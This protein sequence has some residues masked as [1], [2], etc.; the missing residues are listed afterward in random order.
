[1]KK[2]IYI[3]AAALTVFAVS[4]SKDP[5]SGEQGG[6]DKT[7]PV[8]KTIS[9]TLPAVKA[10]LSGETVTWESSDAISVFDG[11][12]NNK[13]TMVSGTMSGAKADFTGKVAGDAKELVAVYPYASSAS[14]TNG[15]VAGSIAS[16]QVPVAAGFD[17]SCFAAVGQV[18]GDAVT[19]KPMVGFVKVT[20]GSS[21]STKT[22]SLMGNKDEAV[23]GDY[24]ATVDGTTVTPE[25]SAAT[26]ILC[27]GNFEGGKSYL[28][29]TFGGLKLNSGLTVSVDLGGGYIATKKITSGVT[30]NAGG[31][32]AVDMAN[33]EVTQISVSY[34]TQSDTL[35]FN[36]GE[37]KEVEVEG[38]NIATIDFDPFGPTGWTTDASKAS[39]GKV[40]ITAPTTLE[41]VDAAANMVLIG[42]AST[43]STTTDT[44]LVRLAGINSKEDLVACRDAIANKVEGGTAPYMV[45]GWIT[46]N[47]DVAIT[48]DD[49]LDKTSGRYFFPVI[50]IPIN[51]QNKTVTIN[52]SYDA[53]ALTGTA[54]YS[55]IQWLKADMKDLTLAGSMEIKNAPKKDIRCGALAGVFGAQGTDTGEIKMTV[56]NVKVAV[57]LTATAPVAGNSIRLAGFAAMV[58]GG[59]ISTNV[60]VKDCE[61]A[62]SFKTTENVREVAGFFGTSGGG[63]PGSIVNISKCKF[64]GTMD[65]AQKA[66]HGTLRI[67]G[68]VGSAERTTVIN[69]C[70]NT[71][72][73]N[74]NA[75]GVALVSDT[76]GLAG[77]CGRTNAQSGTNNMTYVIEDCVNKSTIKVD[78]ALSGD[79][80]QYIQQILA[81]AKSQD[82]LTLSNNTEGGT[83]TINY[84]N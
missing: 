73:M 50:D 12:S 58:T 35:T 48:D 18:S 81:T 6:G 60:T 63:T 47:A 74:V 36:L 32:Y 61:S 84:A 34:K 78:N 5:G 69:K 30:I 7:K 14:Y 52:S 80:I 11:K 82:N 40:S 67:A 23:A 75:G 68:I 56:S 26:S 39:T 21:Q 59:S 62:G 19:L 13:F 79:K 43:G 83:I 76:G 20:L 15:K 22:I 57:S 71:G 41:G 55:F 44:L 3:L 45:D 64:T 51:G 31:V 42:T 17:N 77:I 33:A 38:V 53:S 24:T 9:A 25:A 65:Y 28:L 72:T 8:T 54:Y 70:E 37:T 1:M 27:A 4:C 29:T 16:R 46:L 66:N 10:A 49:M 2:I